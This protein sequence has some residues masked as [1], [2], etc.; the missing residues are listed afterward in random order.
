MKKVSLK[1]AMEL[2]KQA[3]LSHLGSGDIAHLP[4]SSEHAGFMTPALLHNQQLASGNRV[5]LAAG[6]DVLTLVPGHYIGTNFKNSAFPNSPGAIVIVD[7]TAAPGGNGNDYR[8]IVQMLS[9]NGEIRVMNL[10][11]NSTLT[12]KGYSTIER[13][14][15]LWTGNITEV[16]TVLT[17]SDTIANMSAV[18]VTTNNAVGSIKTTLIPKSKSVITLAAGIEDI[19]ITN[20]GGSATAFEMM[21]NFNDNTA[22]ITINTA[23][24]IKEQMKSGTGLMK[25]L[26]IEGVF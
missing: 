18:R 19:N 12:P 4:V 6:D 8:Q 9:V 22:K 25:V 11:G 23:Y 5:W 10:H 7:I 15:P 14:E 3:I 16:G 21:I 20:D 1:K 17:L 2:N 26:S 24:D 13:V